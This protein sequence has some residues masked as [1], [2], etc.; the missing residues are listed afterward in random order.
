MIAIHEMEDPPPPY[1]EKVETLRGGG[2]AQDLAINV[3]IVGETQNGKSTLI[4][5]IGVYSG[6]PDLDV[7]IGFGIFI[8]KTIPC[9][10]SL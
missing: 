5:Q 3:L 2:T 6:V 7:R 4:R 10:L 9:S 8:P 1:K